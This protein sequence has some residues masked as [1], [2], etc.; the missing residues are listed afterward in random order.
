[1]RTATVVCTPHHLAHV[2]ATLNTAI[3]ISAT[4]AA[5]G[6]PAAGSAR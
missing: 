3:V 2:C 1:M 6:R 4:D 5:A